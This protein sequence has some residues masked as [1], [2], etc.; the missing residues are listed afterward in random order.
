MNDDKIGPN[1]KGTQIS[2][3][4]DHTKTKKGDVELSE[5]ELRRPSGGLKYELTNIQISSSSLSSGSE[6]GS[7]PGK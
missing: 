4:E 5:E 7:V 1:K 2:S 3:A 6:G